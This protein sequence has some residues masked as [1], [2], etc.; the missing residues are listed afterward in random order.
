MLYL[1]TEE[2]NTCIREAVSGIKEPVQVN[3]KEWLFGVSKFER[4]FTAFYRSFG[5]NVYPSIC[6]V[7]SCLELS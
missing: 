7:Q 6:S 4:N 1:S 3:F 2:V 5:A